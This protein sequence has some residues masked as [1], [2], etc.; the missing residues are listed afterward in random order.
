MAR[1]K[2]GIAFGSGGIR[3]VSHIGVIQA[4]KENNIPIDMV[5]GSSVGA[6][7][8]AHYALFQDLPELKNKTIG[9]SK[10]KMMAMLEPAMGGGLIAGKKLHKLLQQWFNNKTFKDVKIPLSIVTTDLLTG[11]EVVFDRG[12]LITV[13]RASMAVPT[14]FKPVE[15]KK[16]LLADGG[17]VNPV[18]D[19][20]VRKMGADVVIAVNLDNFE[21]AISKKSSYSGIT[22]V[23]T[24]SLQILRH[25]LASYSIKSADVV[26]EPLAEEVGL[27]GLKSLFNDKQ[28]QLMFEEGY[29]KT[30][31]VMDKIKKLIN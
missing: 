27:I 19:D 18:P 28:K 4:L 6:W 29:R 7:V 5:A 12:D 17:M 8:A 30:M 10:D 11:K 13:V 2:V 1:K 31:M 25:H 15:F 20:I 14:V 23:S 3:G 16:Y 24:R 9:H 22:T 26:I 21:L